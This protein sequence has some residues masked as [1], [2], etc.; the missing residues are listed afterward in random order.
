M[1]KIIIV[2]DKTGNEEKGNYYYQV[3]INYK[4]V[5]EGEIFGYSREQGWEGLLATLNAEINPVMTK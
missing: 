5:G 1:L 2:N 3:F 4:I